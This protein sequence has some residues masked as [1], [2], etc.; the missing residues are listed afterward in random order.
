MCNKKRLNIV[1]TSNKSKRE[2][3]GEIQ[4]LAGAQLAISIAKEG[5]RRRYILSCSDMM[6]G[7]VSMFLDKKRLK[8]LISLLSKSLDQE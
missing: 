1:R 3:V 7:R 2:E 8:E 5:L 6:M 4:D